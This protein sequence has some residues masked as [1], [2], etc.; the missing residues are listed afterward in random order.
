MLPRQR[1]LVRQLRWRWRGFLVGRCCAV[2]FQLRSHPPEHFLDRFE[3]R[4]LGVPTFDA[5]PCPC[6]DASAARSFTCGESHV[7]TPLADLLTDVPIAQYHVPKLPHTHLHP[8][9]VDEV[10]QVIYDVPV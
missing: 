7:D 10:H 8:H 5:S 1:S 2:G 3:Q 6:A 4:V 9:L